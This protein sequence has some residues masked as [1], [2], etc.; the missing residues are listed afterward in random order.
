MKLG[1]LWQYYDLKK[2]ANREKHILA[3][4]D[5]VFGRTGW[6]KAHALS[7]CPQGRYFHVGEI[8]R[9]VFAEAE[10]SLSR[11]NRHTLI[12]TNAGHPRRGTENL[13]G[14]ISILKNEFPDIRL[15]LAGTISTR[16]GYGRFLRRRM[17]ELEIDSHV[18]FLGYL[19]GDAMAQELTSAHIFAGTSY[20]E[21]SPNSLA[22]AMV[23]GVPCVA[24]YVGG[25]P[26]M[27]TDGETGILYPVEDIAL[28]ADSIRTLFSDDALAKRI[29]GRARDLGMRRH[30]P[31][32]VT[33]QLIRGYETIVRSSRI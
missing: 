11:C 1:L 4:V 2:A 25:T 8:L 9:P 10:W 12:F 7:L 24:S 13:F 32:T 29:G 28:L 14:A 30:D 18:D 15:R 21:N 23:V 5:A 19:G 16:S 6:D 27:V 3:A 31:K 26:S 20:I 17:S 33:D 22:E